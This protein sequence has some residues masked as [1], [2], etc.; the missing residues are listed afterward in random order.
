MRYLL[1]TNVVS[2]LRKGGRMD[3]GVRRWWDGVEASEP[4]LSVVV[5]GEILL[6]INRLGRRDPA[7]ARRLGA[8]L[9]SLESTYSERIIDVDGEVMSQWADLNAIRPLP[10]IDSLLGATAMAHGL[11]FI[12]RDTSALDDT[13][14]PMLNPFTSG[15][16]A[17]S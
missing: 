9:G 15:S 12:T 10:G 8:W 2:E 1:D 17:A 6:G 4:A 3:D 14:V 11:V 7:A 5:V 13:G 16:N